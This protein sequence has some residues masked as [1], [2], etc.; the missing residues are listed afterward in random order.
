MPN[1][2]FFDVLLLLGRPAAG[3]SE[4]LEFLRSV[5]DQTRIEKYHTGKLDVIDDFPILWAWF[6]EDTILS[7]KFGK[8]RLH[9]DGDRYFKYQYLIPNITQSNLKYSGY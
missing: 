9:S 7:E 3:K 4:I 6:E 5:D 1:N 8:P 2:G